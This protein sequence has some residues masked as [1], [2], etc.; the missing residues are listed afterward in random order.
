MSEGD[1]ADR[2]DAYLAGHPAPIT[3]AA[4]ALALG[5]TGP[6]RIAL[7]TTALEHLMERD[8]ENGRP[9]RAAWAVSRATGMPARG[10]FDRAA[11]LG[12]YAGPAEGDAAFVAGMRED[13]LR[14]FF[15]H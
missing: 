4:L 8:A 2:L 1:L 12:R 7:I 5:L 11:A 3:Y 14:D 6:G 9:F 13:L 10:F 15:A